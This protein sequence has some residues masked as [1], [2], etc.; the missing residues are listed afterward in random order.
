MVVEKGDLGLAISLESSRNVLGEEWQS[1]HWH[2]AKCHTY[3]LGS[4]QIGKTDGDVPSLPHE[5]SATLRLGLARTSSQGEGEDSQS[6]GPDEGMESWCTLSAVCAKPRDNSPP[7]Y[8]L[9]RWWIEHHCSRSPVLDTIQKSSPGFLQGRNTLEGEKC[10]ENAIALKMV[11]VLRR[12]RR[13]N[14]T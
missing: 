2:F 8:W 12:W 5:G 14:H 4:V 6:W 3:W 10:C 7:G 11:S 13:Q 9:M 1:F